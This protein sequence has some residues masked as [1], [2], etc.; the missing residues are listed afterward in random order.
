MAARSMAKYGR[1]AGSSSAHPV[2]EC[3]GNFLLEDE[4]VFVPSAIGSTRFGNT[5][6][7]EQSGSM[8]LVSYAAERIGFDFEVS[9]DH[10]FPWLDSMGHA[11]YA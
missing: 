5:L 7:T 10:Y 6:M 8:Q 2:L 9:S 3:P 11:P 1:F 4:V